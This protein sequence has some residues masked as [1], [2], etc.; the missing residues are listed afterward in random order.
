VRMTEVEVK[1]VP[2]ENGAFLEGRRAEIILEGKKVG[3]FGELHPEVILNFGLS[4]PVV[5]FEVL[6]RQ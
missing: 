1:V 6:L 5:G 3:V 2:S 4:Q